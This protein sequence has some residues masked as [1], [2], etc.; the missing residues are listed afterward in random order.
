VKFVQKKL[1]TIQQVFYWNYHLHFIFLFISQ[2]NKFIAETNNGFD[3]IVNCSG[4]GARFFVQDE[5]V[6]AVRGQ[7]LRVKAPWVK[8]CI[9][10]ETDK[11]VTYILP[12]SDLVV[13]G[14]SQEH[15]NYS[16]DPKEDDLKA[17][18]QRCSRFIPSLKVSL[19]KIGYWLVY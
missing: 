4:L 11:E 9:M 5:N 12:L 7:V 13:L 2:I 10:F 6:F 3:Y 16:L 14:G 18:A 17:I 8:C 15:E 19:F 1:S